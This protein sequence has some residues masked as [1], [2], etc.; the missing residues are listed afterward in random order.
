M[1][2]FFIFN[3]GSR[4]GQ[5]AP[6]IAR[7]RSLLVARKVIFECAIT[8]SLHDACTLSKE[9][10]RA[11]YDVVVAVG[12]DGTINR[13]INGF[14][15]E[16]GSRLSR[17]SLGVIYTGTSPDFCKSY[18]VPYGA[19]ERSLDVLLAGRTTQIQLGQITLN[20]AGADGCPGQG[21]PERVTRYFACCVNIGLGASVARE[22]NA[23]GRK[24]WGDSVGTLRAIIRSFRQYR[25]LKLA[26]SCDG[27][28]EIWPGLCNL[29]IGKTWH[30]AS[31]IKV[32][33]T[34]IEG[35]GRFYLLAV[36]DV[37]W[38]H[39]PHCLMA[40]YSGKPISNSR[41]ISLAYAR[42]V[43]VKADQPAVEVE[44]DGDPQGFLPCGVTMAKDKLELIHA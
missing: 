16:N 14:Y 27:R 38:R 8:G 26:V 18:A 11:G 4:H 32:N 23:G 41:Q 31:G 42:R 15:D 7:L 22:A 10:N 39:V 3:P 5:S 17:A 20:T 43:D 29:S 36:K 28:A 6:L 33:G 40:V 12:G 2:Y 30:I 44:F 1:R 9:A 35:D 24:R 19:I 25:R 13:V 37:A 34:L 21:V